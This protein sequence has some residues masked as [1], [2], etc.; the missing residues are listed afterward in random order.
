L[1]F[2]VFALIELVM[3]WSGYGYQTD[4][5]VADDTG[6]YYMLNPDLSKKYFTIEENATRGNH[7]Y[8][9]QKK[10]PG[11]IRMFVLGASSAIGY[12]YMHNA[13]FSRLLKYRMQFLYPDIN[14]EIINLSLT[15][16]NTYTLYDFSRQLIAYEPDAIL[17]Y[18]G[19]NEYY[20]ALGAASTSYMGSNP[21]VIRAILAAKN[22]KTVQWLFHL[23]ASWKSV[24]QRFVDYDRTLMERMTK[25]QS[26]PYQSGVFHRGIKQFERN[27]GDML[28]LFNKHRIPVFI[29]TLAYNQRDLKPFI[30]STDSLSA[31]AQY[32]KGH[33]A[34]AEGDYAA[35]KAC[36][37]QAKEYDEL[38][39]RAP[40]KINTLIRRYAQAYE[41][42]HPAEVLET[43][44]RHSPHG[45]LDSTL[46][47]E[48]V[49][50]NLAGQQ[51]IADAFYEAIATSGI[52][53]ETHS[54]LSARLADTNYSFPTHDSIFGTVAIR[55][56]KQLWP[57]DEPV[58]SLPVNTYEERLAVARAGNRI[59]WYECMRKLY[60]YYNQAGDY[61]Q[62]LRILE[63]LYLEYPYDEDYIALTAQVSRQLDEEEKAWFYSRKLNALHPSP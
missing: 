39:F 12:P 4:L 42:V 16:V 7:E 50:P 30:S 29:G 25:E 36:Y 43:F 24:D 1:P 31:N 20:G 33:A 3:R 21:C 47:L 62:V 38:R 40:E 53:P 11:T 17:V 41:T 15:A 56:L 60:A 14:L 48:H 22:L 6:T 27:M 59:T 23:T 52:L 18:A 9:R 44:E 46:L 63:G 28:K 26:I 58:D 32:E 45:I 57:F 54:P 34:Y 8:F 13:A 55:L 5:F 2:V 35:A 37:R 51:L 61:A 10:A 19:H 49:H